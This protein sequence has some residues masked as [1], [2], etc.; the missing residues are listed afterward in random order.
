MSE[1]HPILLAED[2]PYDAELTLAAFQ[3]AGLANRVVHVVDGVEA[4]EFLR[5]EGKF[6]GRTSGSPAVVV[7]DIK[8]P[9][10]DGIEVLR[11]IRE[12]PK[13]QF[14]PVVMLT[15]SRESH[16]LLRSYQLGTNAYVVKPV[17]F[18]DFMA[19]VKEIGLFWALINEH[20]LDLANDSAS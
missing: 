17:K 14:L 4:L 10:L 2:S 15:S 20:A 13:L 18:A 12:D 8:M 19:A 3:N 1:L 5:C 11:A 9:R 16:D 7:L 6:V